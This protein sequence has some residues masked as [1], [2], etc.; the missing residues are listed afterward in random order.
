MAAQC[1]AWE[2]GAWQEQGVRQSSRAAHDE[3]GQRRRR[4]IHARQGAAHRRGACA[5]PAHSHIQATAFA[6]PMPCYY[7]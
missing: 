7:N 5:Q 3:R 4:Q 1:V 6:C 2:V